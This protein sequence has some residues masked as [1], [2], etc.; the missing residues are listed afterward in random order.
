MEQIFGPGGL[1]ARAHPE[2]EY[3][4]GQVLMAAAVMRAFEERRHLIVE[5][6]TG[7]GKTLAY[8]V[9]A[10]AAAV[11]RG[12]RVVISTGTKNLQEQLMGK[13]IPF[14]QRV[15]PRGFSAAYMKGRGNY[16]C[17]NRV[18]RAETTPILDGLDDIDYFDEV[19]RW[20]RESAT[21]DRAEL[22]EL[23]EN[24][25]FWRHIDARSETCLGQKCADYDACFITRMRQRASDSDLIIVNHHLF[26]AD[27]ALRGGEYGQVIPDYSAVIF[28]E[29]HQIEDV[30][31][32]YFG[33]QVS[34]YQV[35][36][37]LR[38]LQ[39]L[40]I[41]D[42][43]LNRELTRAGNRVARF[44][45]QFW[46]GF[47]EA[48][49]EEG[50]GALLPGTFARRNRAGEVEATP[51]GESYL[52]LDGALQR[53][54]ATLDLI[55]DRPP[56]VDNLLRRIRE[57]RFHLEFI[58]AG[59]DRRYVYWV[60]RRGRGVFL[61]ASPI[62]VSALL[63]DKL[64][65]RVE[66]VVLTSATLASAG[67]FDFIRGRLG[68]AAGGEGF[69]GDQLAAKT[70]ELVAPSGYD[71]ERQAVLYLP[72][73][74]P[75]PRSPQWAEAAAE[76]VVR[77]LEVSRGRAFILSTSLSGMRALYE[78]VAPRVEF[79][80][81]VQGT[82]SKAGLLERFRETPGAV[83]FATASFWQGVDVRGEQLSCVVI[84]KLPFA[85]P[86][87]PV[88]AARQRFIEEQ[89]GSSFYEFSVPQAV[90]TLKQGVGRLIRS[91][92]DRG[93]LAVLDPR[94]RTQGY[95]RL[96]LQSLPPCRVTSDIGE[97]AAVFGEELQVPKFKVQSSKFKVK[98]PA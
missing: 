31:A 52:S 13:D 79:P 26:F 96:F 60:E 59:D 62:D 9:P 71:Y 2:Y 19:R 17:L 48:R 44:A 65:E 78:L 86:T 67:R 56:E 97:A 74:M 76:E 14:L 23:P 1:I 18:K 30:A 24:L 73:R 40:P 83:L 34:S 94:L 5:A 16:A 63:Q 64:F 8:L 87:D 42:A 85:V 6:G 4:P 35:E 20:A 61:R 77:L 72:P 37:M 57:A 32:E 45:E 38:D 75:D 88:V 93:L 12:T 68:L 58:V 11:E 70:D 21:G 46:M 39:Q 80:C 53:V 28:D 66:T 51:L 3:R 82:A 10:V 7:T 33:F 89:G 54:E 98:N 90:I 95:G 41:T 69:G 22:T 91:T 43:G 15:L 27:L 36:D 29:A 55:K 47:K 25:S 49:G 50:R 81:F 92:T 84:D